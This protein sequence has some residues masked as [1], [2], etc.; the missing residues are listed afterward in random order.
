MSRR[1]NEADIAAVT[2]VVRAYYDG[3]IEGDAVKLGRAFR[4]AGVHR[5][6]RGRRAVLGDPRR[7]HGRVRGGSLTC[8]GLRMANRT[9]LVRG[10]HS[11]GQPRRPIRRRVVQR[12]P[13]PRLD[14]RRMAHRA[15]DVLHTPRGLT[16]SFATTRPPGADLEVHRGTRHRSNGPD[17]WADRGDERERTGRFSGKHATAPHRS[18]HRSP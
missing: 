10:R 7:V 16:A 9:P 8:G 17:S 12:R 6:Q 5:R 3:M 1:T 2:E 14:R 15:Q 4:S 11:P 18:R 13:V